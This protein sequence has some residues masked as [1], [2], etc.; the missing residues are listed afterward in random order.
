MP[1][2][3]AGLL[4]YLLFRPVQFIEKQG[5]KRVWAILLLY[6]V[7]IVALGTIFYFA[8]PG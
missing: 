7:I 3:W 1:F 2:I 6:V 5:L 4:A 8:L